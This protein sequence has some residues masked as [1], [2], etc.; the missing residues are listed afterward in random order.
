MSNQDDFWTT[1]AAGHT[2]T[3]LAGVLDEH[4]SPTDPAL[5][6]RHL[7]D[8]LRAE[9]ALPLPVKN[10]TRVCF[11]GGLGAHLTYESVPA[12]GAFGEVVTVKSA[13]GHITEHD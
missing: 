8:K 2:N 6:V 12:D 7:T 3:V 1:I 9:N 10:G 11:A 4:L 5:S 13:N